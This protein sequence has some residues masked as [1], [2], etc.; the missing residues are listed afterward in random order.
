MQ[1]FDHCRTAFDN[2]SASSFQHNRR[3]LPVGFDLLAR[4]FERRPAVTIAQF[5]IRAVRQQQCSDLRLA[6]DGRSVQRRAEPIYLIDGGLRGQQCAH[7][8]DKTAGCR[9]VEADVRA[10]FQQVARQLDVAFLIG[11]AQRRRAE[12]VVNGIEVRAVCEQQINDGAVVVDGGE[13]QWRRAC[14]SGMQQFRGVL[15]VCDNCCGVAVRNC[16]EEIARLIS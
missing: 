16:L 4:D 1:G 15:Q 13:V 11:P 6:P 9:E 7:A 14:V 5:S 3:S 12:F 2:F 10:A 8:F